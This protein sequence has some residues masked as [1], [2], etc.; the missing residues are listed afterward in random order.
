MYFHGKNS[1]I[2]IINLSKF[3]ERVR[4]LSN[5]KRLIYLNILLAKCGTEYTVFSLESKCNYF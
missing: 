1:R 5:H 2:A 4:Y 3:I